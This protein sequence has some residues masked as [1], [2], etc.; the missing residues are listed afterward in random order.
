MSKRKYV[1]SRYKYV[2]PPMDLE[3]P[4]YEIDTVRL[5]E[6][7]IISAEVNVNI[8]TIYSVW[9]GDL[10]FPIMDTQV[11]AKYL[12]PVKQEPI[13][14]DREGEGP[15]YAGYNIIGKILK[16]VHEI[17]DNIEVGGSHY[18]VAIQPWDY[19]HANGLGFDEGNIVK[20]ATRHKK[21]GGA[22]DVKKIISYAKHILKTQYGDVGDDE[23]QAAR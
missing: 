19:I 8:A 23:E 16:S 17:K 3:S 15:A 2:G 11:A 14:F 5:R 10:E 21:K 22:E 1:T 18:Q 4:V 20:Y 9:S 13:H 7:S 6:G 12:E